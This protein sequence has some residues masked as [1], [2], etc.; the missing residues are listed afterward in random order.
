[1]N[2]VFGFIIVFA[3]G[4]A[5]VL[6][7]V[8]VFEMNGYSENEILIGKAVI[9]FIFILIPPILVIFGRNSKGET[10]LE[11]L[12]K[13]VTSF[14]SMVA[15]VL[16]NPISMIIVLLGIIINILVWK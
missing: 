13:P 11:Q 9:M 8:H 2:F 1:M 7:G 14:A 10:Q 15:H 6:A 12:G 5:A 16:T 3:V 4:A